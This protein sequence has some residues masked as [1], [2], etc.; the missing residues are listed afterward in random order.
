MKTTQ[1][2]FYFECDSTLLVEFILHEIMSC[3]TH[4][5][6]CFCVTVIVRVDQNNSLLIVINCV[7]PGILPRPEQLAR[8]A[9]Y[10]ERGWELPYRDLPR[11]HICGNQA[12]TAAHQ[13]A[14]EGHV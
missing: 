13:Q 12:T 11:T 10:S 7:S 4:I 8:E 1:Q 2:L 6:N 14:L 5:F 3:S 9:Y